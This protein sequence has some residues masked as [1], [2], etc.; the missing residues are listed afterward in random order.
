[1]TAATSLGWSGPVPACLIAIQ[2]RPAG[3]SRQDPLVERF[4][5]S[6]L[7]SERVGTG[8]RISSSWRP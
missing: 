3:A 4:E 6:D 7:I 5:G 1:M 2:P 8:C